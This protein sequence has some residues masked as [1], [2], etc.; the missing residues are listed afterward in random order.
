MIFDY[1]SKKMKLVFEL[2]DDGCLMLKKLGVSDVEPLP[3]KNS[4]FAAACEL[5]I[6]GENPLR[7]QSICNSGM[8]GS[9]N[10]KYVSHTCE[11]LPDGKKLEFLLSDGNKLEV[12]A[13]YRLYDN[14]DVIRSWTTV[15]NVSDEDLGLEYVSS[16]ALM[17]MDLGSEPADDKM[18]LLIPHSTWEAEAQWQEY[19]MPQLGTARVT[20]VSAKRIHISNT[21]TWSCKEYLPMGALI[22]DETADTLMWQ[23]EHNGSWQWEISVSDGKQLLRLSGPDEK[24]NG[25]WKNLKPGESFETVKAAIAVSDSLDGVIAEMTA[26]RRTIAK[27]DGADA[28]LPI[29]FNDYMNCLKADPTE[30]KELPMIDRAQAAGAE[31]Y[32]IDAGWYADGTWWDTVGEWYECSWRFPHGLKFVLDYIRSKGMIP[33]LWVEPEVMGINCPIVN[34]FEDE[35]FFMG[36][37]KRVISRGRYQLDYRHPK[38]REYILSVFD[39]LIA[40]YGV[41]YFKLDYNIEAGVGTEVDSDSFGDGLLEHNR[42]VLSLLDEITA[43]YPDVIFENCSSGGMRMEYASLAHSHIQSTSDQ[44][45]YRHYAHIAAA[46]GTAILPE[47]AAV[48]S[49]PKACDS[50]DGTIMNMVNSMPL[51]VHLSGELAH[52]SEEQLALVKEGVKVMKDIRKDTDSSVPF[53]PCGLPTYTDKLFCAAY[54]C[55]DCVRVAAWRL[56]TDDDTLYIPSDGNTVKVLYPSCFDGE[57]YTAEGCVVIKLPREYTAVFVEIR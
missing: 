5:H 33:G 21:G 1:S 56:D 2:A 52:L 54:K 35:C 38:V 7:R 31:L 11:T 36:H 42:A 53:Y 51:R 55:T 6:T 8:Y 50:L 13:H 3:V 57:A 30:E 45:D 40:E 48:W 14:I 20:P 41:G 26:Y 16:F 4:H 18:R 46:V 47:Q 28:K 44:T 24:D 29:I 49:Y 19:T 10:L 17:G 39:R 9:L 32:V 15:K 43:K 37:G 27:R 23:I 22:N 12:T 34:K 25:W